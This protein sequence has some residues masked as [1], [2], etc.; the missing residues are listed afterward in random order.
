MRNPTTNVSPSSRSAAASINPAASSSR[1]RDF[2]CRK[3]LLDLVT[4]EFA[5]IARDQARTEVAVG[6][7]PAGRTADDGG[8]VGQIDGVGDDGRRRVGVAAV[9]ASTVTASAMP[10]EKLRP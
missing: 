8:M 4:C 9:F 2:P 5:D 10:S 1:A 7:Q 6:L 3:R